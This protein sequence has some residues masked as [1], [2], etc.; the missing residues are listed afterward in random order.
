MENGLAGTRAVEAHLQALR[1]FA[2][3]LLRGERERAEDLVQDSV[4]RA[5]AHWH[6]RRDD[7]ELR[8]WLF[9]ILYNRFITDLRQRKREFQQRALHEVPEGELPG[10]DGGQERALAC[11]DLLRGFAELPP[12]QRAVLLLITAQDFSYEDAAR[13]LGIPIGTVMSRLS[14]GRERLRRYMNEGST[15]MRPVLLAGD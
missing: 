14:R 12:D 6:Q 11:R 15:S 4:E 3:A 13:V 7:G 10:L 2:C 8:S 9:A 5:L 1:R